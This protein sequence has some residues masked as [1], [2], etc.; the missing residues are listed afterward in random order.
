MDGL[1]YSGSSGS[2]HQCA[3]HDSSLHMPSGTLTS[4]KEIG[5]TKINNNK[6]SSTTMT[7]SE[8]TKGT[9]TPIEIILV[10]QAPFELVCHQSYCQTIFCVN[11]LTIYRY[12]PIRYTN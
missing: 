6:R 1:E 11:R 5:S 10:I 2:K 3:L 4:N 7:V 8:S 9:S 12:R